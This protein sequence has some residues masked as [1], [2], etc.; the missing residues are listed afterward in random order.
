LR[1]P[2]SDGSERARLPRRFAAFSFEIPDRYR[3][4]HSHV[5]DIRHAGT[6]QSLVNSPKAFEL[7]PEGQAALDEIRRWCTQNAVFENKIDDRFT[8]SLKASRKLAIF[9][10][11]H[12][13]PSHLGYH[14]FILKSLTGAGFTVMIV[15]AANSYCHG[16]AAVDIPN[17]FAVL[18]RNIGYDFGS[19]AVGV[20]AA[21]DSLQL[22]DELILINDSILQIADDLAPMIA[23]FRA[24]DADALS[25]TDSFE[26]K[27]HL[28]SYM[29]WFGPDVCR[30]NF[31]PQ[32]MSNYSFTSIKEDA[33]A[34]GEIGLSR[35]LLSEGFRIKALF[36]YE[37]VSSAWIR[38]Y[39]ATVELVR[40]LP[41]LPLDWPGNS[42]N[43]TLLERLD[44]LI[45]HVL[46][47]N[48]LNPSHFFWDTLVEDFGFPFIKRELIIS[49]PC[50]VPTYFKLATHL[51]MES[52]VETAIVEIRRGY[53][54][55]LIPTSIPLPQAVSRK[56]KRILGND[57]A[58]EPVDPALRLF[59]R[60]EI[61]GVVARIGVNSNKGT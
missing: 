53:G 26:R 9:S 25:C 2:I 1:G 4:G 61:N 29:L 18:K 15:H 50:N 58:H 48:P 34:E 40:N 23:R 46:S 17:C 28:Q 12:D 44:I 22:V 54:G 8:Q 43:K 21:C 14:H 6:S 45:T 27:Y 37:A 35:A 32:F 49:N 16:L 19:Y 10:T 38:G 41:G 52:E 47:G 24:L 33:I 56:K 59:R 3:D 31:L 7:H 51:L 20:F 57:Y 11:Y 39:D 13:L 42:F 30:S 60:P 36:D 55:Q 5:I